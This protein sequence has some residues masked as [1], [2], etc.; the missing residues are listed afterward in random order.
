VRDAGRPAVSD[1]DRLVEL[2]VQLAEIG[3]RAVFDLVVELREAD[4]LR[5]AG[6]P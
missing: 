1:G 6:Y 2:P 5:E 3:P 4:A